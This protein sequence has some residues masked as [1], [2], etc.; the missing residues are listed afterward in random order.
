M[1]LLDETLGWGSY[2]TYQRQNTIIILIIIIVSTFLATPLKQNLGLN[3][4]EYVCH[5]V[6]VIEIP[7]QENS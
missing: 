7:D 2:Y 4:E 6:N 1:L 5:I 3:R